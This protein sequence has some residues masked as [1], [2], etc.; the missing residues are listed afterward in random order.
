MDHALFVLEVG[1]AT[2]V[3][4]GHAA[5]LI[6]CPE[7]SWAAWND[8][9]LRA[10]GPD[11]VV[12]TTGAPAAIAGLYGLLAGMTRAGRKDPVRMSHNMDDERVGNLVAAWLQ[13]E[14]SVFPIALEGDWPGAVLMVGGLRVSSRL[15]AGDLRWTVAGGG[16]SVE[17]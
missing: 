4:L 11:A 5:L 6:D 12:F 13:S 16:R 3:S 7:G 8:A 2:A 1:G 9:G 15:E 10:T 14:P 17:R